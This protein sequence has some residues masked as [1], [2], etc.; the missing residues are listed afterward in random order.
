MNDP[1][2]ANLKVY[3]D[4][5]FDEHGERVAAVA[6]LVGTEAQ[7][8]KL[9][10]AWLERT[11]GQEFHANKCE[12]QYAR[13]PDP[14]KHRGA[15]ALYKDL[16][17]LV[18]DSGLRGY[19]SA[20]DLASYREYLPGENPENGF[21]HSFLGVLN[22]CSKLAVEQNA[23]VEF[24][25]DNRQ[26]K[27]YNA[28]LLFKAFRGSPPWRNK[29]IF[30]RPEIRFD[31]RKNPRIQAADLVARESMKGLDNYIGPTRRLERQS[32]KLL[33]RHGIEFV[34]YEGPYFRDFREKLTELKE[35]THFKENEYLDWL[36]ESKRTDNQSNRI[37]FI[38]YKDQSDPL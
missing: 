35:R 27:E 18:A 25:F 33:A 13:D 4:E 36:A 6:A 5:S 9:E 32:L 16:A 3:G 34:A 28:N 7:W 23:L 12:T 19:G 30:S 10:A 1:G 26:G 22:Y 24:I 20:F 37:H 15:L 17:Q 2:S 29:N 38:I 14:E 8:A 31:T 21:I 11:G